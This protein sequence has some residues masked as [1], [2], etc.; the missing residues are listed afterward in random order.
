MTTHAA[1]AHLTTAS[2]EGG[3]AALDQEI[4]LT[5]LGCLVVLRC[6]LAIVAA[7]SWGAG[8]INNSE[9]KICA[10]AKPATR[11]QRKG[12]GMDAARSP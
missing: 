2:S 6:T 12:R 4:G 11:V 1:E 3:G 5:A 8:R 9:T 10:E 7:L